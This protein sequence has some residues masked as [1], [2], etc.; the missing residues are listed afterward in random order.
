MAIL[1]SKP[2]VSDED[3]QTVIDTLKS[4]HLEDGNIVIK[5][6]DQI[7]TLIGRKYAAA[8][9]S[10]F[11]A[12]H[13]SLI[14]LNIS[15]GDE[16]ILP[17]YT[18]P[19]LLN[20]ILI[21]KATPVF[22]DIEENS[23]NISSNT[24]KN[25]ISEKTKAIIAPHMYGFP[26][27]INEISKFGI[28]VIEDCTQSI[29]GI[30][31]GKRMGTFSEISVFSFYATKMFTS[32]DG[33]MILTDNEEIYNSAINHRYYGHKKNHHFTAYNY[34]LTNLRAS[35]GISQSKRVESFIEQRKKIAAIYLKSFSENQY[36]HTDFKNKDDSVYYRFPILIKKR[37]QL[38]KIL[39]KNGIHTG[40]GTLEGLHQLVNKNDIHFPNTTKY[41]NQILSIPIYPDLT[42][43]QINYVTDKVNNRSKEIN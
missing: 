42:D 39:L 15:E 27:D 23:F 5:F 9:N 36:I 20:P 16:V 33:G 43:N 22:A 13:L 14:A 8:T 34:H 32:G 26:A 18:C 7:K 17:S 38:K 10:G 3:I 28:P 6:E 29:G 19:A 12:I 2:I 1:H 35:L 11:S 25:K 37:D 21:Q 40:Y 4:G 31:N 41:L 24:I 30:I